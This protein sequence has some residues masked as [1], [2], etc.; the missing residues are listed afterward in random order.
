MRDF[1]WSKCRT[2]AQRI[3]S[4]KKISSDEKE[5]LLS[6]PATLASLNP[7]SR[8]YPLQHAARYEGSQKDFNEKWGELA[9]YIRKAHSQKNPVLTSLDKDFDESKWQVDI[10]HSGPTAKKSPTPYLVI[11]DSR[12]VAAFKKLKK[13]DQINAEASLSNGLSVEN[14]FSLEEIFYVRPAESSSFSS[15]AMEGRGDGSTSSGQTDF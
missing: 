7:K 13:G 4:E 8:K 15:E 11:R 1:I 2:F 3:Y 10:L 14:D 12:G 6:G 5:I 9:L